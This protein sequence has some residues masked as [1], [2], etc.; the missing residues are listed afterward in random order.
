M[1]EMGPESIPD[2]EPL[3]LTHPSQAVPAQGQK[4]CAFPR[5]WQDIWLTPDANKTT[6]YIQGYFSKINKENILTL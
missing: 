3:L 2:P 6:R 5:L 4:D 1:E